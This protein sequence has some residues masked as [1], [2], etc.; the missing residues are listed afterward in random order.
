MNRKM[1]CVTNRL[2]TTH[3]QRKEGGFTLI[4]L[5]IVIVILGVLAGIA[6][7]ALDGFKD[8]AEGA[9][10]GANARIDSTISAANT[11]GGN[12]SATNRGDC[13]ADN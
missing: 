2:N 9:C 13:D 11:A 12:A 10:S 5:L 1:D 7:F 8:D 4:E 3:A 6:I